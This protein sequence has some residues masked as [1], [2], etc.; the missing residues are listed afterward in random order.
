MGV[1]DSESDKFGD[2]NLQTIFVN[3]IIINIF[4]RWGVFGLSENEFIGTLLRI[5][6]NVH[7]EFEFNDDGNPT[8]RNRE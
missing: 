8:S 1:V 6:K 5:Y 3:N 2:R 7:E 4:F